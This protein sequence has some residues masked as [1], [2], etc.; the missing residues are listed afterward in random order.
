LPATQERDQW[1]K[2]LL[3]KYEKVIE[4]FDKHVQELALVQAK[5]DRRVEQLNSL[6][7]SVS[8]TQPVDMAL[9]TEHRFPQ[10][11]PWHKTLKD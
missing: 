8:V 11:P 9:L 6:S 10:S 5:I 2:I 7:S 3:E 1:D 4:D